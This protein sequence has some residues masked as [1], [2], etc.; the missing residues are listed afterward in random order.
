MSWKQNKKLTFI[1]FNESIAESQ[2]Y[3]LSEA[4][5]L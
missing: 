3:M 5:F 4:N 2:F 1:G